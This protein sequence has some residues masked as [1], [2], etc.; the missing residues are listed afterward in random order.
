MNA[1]TDRIGWAICTSGT[2]HHL[3]SRR[4]C[5]LIAA[6]RWYATQVLERVGIGKPEVLV[7]S[8][9]V[10]RG[11]PHPDPFLEGARRCQ[12]PDNSRGGSNL[13]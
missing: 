8:E 2:L 12:A 9:D 10:Q 5:S 7:T 13:F 1:P 11:K 4:H 3:P 6:T